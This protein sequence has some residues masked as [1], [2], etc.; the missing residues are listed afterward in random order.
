MVIAIGCISLS[1]SWLTC[2][3]SVCTQV[4]AV[5]AAIGR[6][7]RNLS[8]NAGG[9]EEEARHLLA[10]RALGC[11]VATARRQ[12]ADEGSCGAGQIWCWM[13]CQSIEQLD[14]DKPDAQCRNPA[15]ALSPPRLWPQDYLVRALIIPLPASPHP[16]GLNAGLFVLPIMRG[17]AYKRRG[18]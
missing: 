15:D 2:A 9:S 1:V 6:E 3:T 11:H 7:V 4:G 10:A 14:C 5:G 17:E 13:S 8:L 12:L 18:A 16:S